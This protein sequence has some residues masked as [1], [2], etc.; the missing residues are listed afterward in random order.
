MSV[1]AST[2]VLANQDNN[3]HKNGEESLSLADSH[4]L[5]SEPDRAD[6]ISTG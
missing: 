5:S 4:A 2:Y 6:G 1:E 3:D